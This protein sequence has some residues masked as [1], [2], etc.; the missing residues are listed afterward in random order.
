MMRSVTAAAR[1]QARVFAGS[2]RSRKRAEAKGENQQNG[3]R[4]PHLG[5]MVHERLVCGIVEQSG[6]ARQV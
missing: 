4:A 3:E 5:L 1:G 6:P 2:E